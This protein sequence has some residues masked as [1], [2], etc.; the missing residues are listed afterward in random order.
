MLAFVLVL[1]MMMAYQVARSIELEGEEKTDRGIEIRRQDQ[2]R[3]RQR[4]QA[5][6]QSGYEN[7]T[8]RQD[9]SKQDITFGSDVT[10]ESASAD[11]S[12]QGRQL[13]TELAYTIVGRGK[14]GTVRSLAEIQVSGHTD[15]VSTDPDVFASNWELSTARATRVV[16][17]LTQAGVD[18]QNVEMSATG[19]GKFAPRATNATPTG[20]AR[21]RRIE[22][23]LVYTDTLSSRH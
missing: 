6:K 10:F 20:R 15:T 14:G 18:P 11:L 7:I 4:I 3:V 9:G 1:V 17:S 13:L 16:K 2:Q 23:R 12:P 22:M 19:Y 21:N 5:F 8:I